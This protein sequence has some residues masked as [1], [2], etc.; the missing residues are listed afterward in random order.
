[1]SLLGWLVAALFGGSL[2][3]LSVGLGV[4]PEVV[5]PKTAELSAAHADPVELERLSAR[6]G[7][8]RLLQ[9]FEGAALRGQQ[10]AALSAL[11]GLGLM[12]SQDPELAAQTVGPLLSYLE[13][14]LP[15]GTSKRP[16]DARLDLAAVEALVRLC[17]TIGRHSSCDELDDAACGADLNEVPRRLLG[18]AGETTLGAPLRAELLVALSAL[19][20]SLWRSQHP[21]LST[22]AAAASDPRDLALR[23][24]ALSTL[25]LLAQAEGRPVE[26]VDLNSPAG[27]LVELTKNTVDS[28]LAAAAA[29]ELCPLL[30][31]SSKNGGARK[32]QP[33][34]PSPSQLLVD[35][36]P[37][38]R[39]LADPAEPLAQRQRLVECLRLLGTPSDR[40][41]LNSI[42]QAGHAATAPNKK[43]AR[44]GTPR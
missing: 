9:A 4:V 29:A 31:P 25:S 5:L 12:G 36:G 38:L 32:G 26:P 24:A 16:R 21:R 18:L 42:V 34:S 44:N 10:R 2:T 43:P 11:L 20:V 7:P 19:P 23:S 22:L 37:Q 40:A 3:G 41:L 15:G 35:L 39:A 1:M 13:R 30:H 14:S 17:S 6:L 28:G 33:A 27:T 8:V